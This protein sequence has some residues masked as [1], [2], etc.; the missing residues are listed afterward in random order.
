MVRM[1][2]GHLLI[3]VIGFPIR[4]RSADINALEL[5][6]QPLEQLLVYFSTSI[7]LLTS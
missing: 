4:F 6:E 2:G 7:S 1:L 5:I 3:I